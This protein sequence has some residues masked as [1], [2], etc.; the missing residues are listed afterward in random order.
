MVSLVKKVAE[1]PKLPGQLNINEEEY[2]KFLN[3]RKPEEDTRSPL[4][5]EYSNLIKKLDSVDDDTSIF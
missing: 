3:Y 5:K 2:N 1:K 4:D